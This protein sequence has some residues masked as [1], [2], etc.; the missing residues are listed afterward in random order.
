MNK[1]NQLNPINIKGKSQTYSDFYTFNL[2][3]ASTNSLLVVISY[4]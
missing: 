2:S 1:P 4:T 3:P